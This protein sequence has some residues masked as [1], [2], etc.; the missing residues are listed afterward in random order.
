M[1]QSWHGNDA[2]YYA[3]AKQTSR[4]KTSITP[5]NFASNNIRYPVHSLFPSRQQVEQQYGTRSASWRPCEAS[6]TSAHHSR[7]RTCAA[8]PPSLCASRTISKS[9]PRR[10]T[11]D[12][13]CIHR[14]YCASLEST[15]CAMGSV[16][17]Q[18]RSLWGLRSWHKLY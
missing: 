10:H 7:A 1:A 13:R 15:L 17:V 8:P 6:Q 12:N 5:A 16:A 3:S 18:G 11:R 2:R 9:H 14:R 4:D